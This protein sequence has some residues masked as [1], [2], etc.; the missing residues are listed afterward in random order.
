MAISSGSIHVKL[1]D[2]SIAWTGPVL[3]FDGECGLC[4]ACVRW[5]IRRDRAAHLR[6]APLQGAPG[7]MYLRAHDLPGENFDSMVFAPSWPAGAAPLFRTDA[8]LAA[9]RTIGGDWSRGLGWLRFVP[10]SWRDLVY[11]LIA[12]I[13]Y[14]L[15]GPPADGWQ[16]APS[17]AD[18][19]I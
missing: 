6:F 12:R 4:A 7:Q 2:Q 17:Y 1:Q 19:F 3:L 11:R 9:L 13:R 14:H 18:R 8:A 10:V 5:M 16:S 15:A